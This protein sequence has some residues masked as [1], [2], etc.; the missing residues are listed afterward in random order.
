MPKSRYLAAVLAVCA[1]PALSVFAEE[2]DG[3]R[4][5]PLE[6]ELDSMQHL[7]I[8]TLTGLVEGER[9]ELGRGDCQ[10]I[11]THTDADFE[12]G[13]YTA[14]AGFSESE[15]AAASYTLAP[16]EFP[17]IVDRVEMIF[18][19]VGTTVTT[20][21]KWSVGVW[22]GTPNNGTLVALFSSDGTILPHIV[23]PPGNSGVNVQVEV[24][25]ND[26]E[27]I[28]VTNNGSNTFTV[29]YRI[30]EHHNQTA[31]PCFTAPPQTSNAFPVTDTSGLANSTG[32]WLFGLNCG[33]F[34]CPTNGGWASFATLNSLC[35]PSGDWVI[36]ATYTPTTCVNDIG[37][38][39]FSNGLCF[40]MTQADC[41][42]VDGLFNGSDTLCAD[43]S[44][45]IGACCVPDGSCLDGVFEET[46]EIEL[47]GL[48]LGDETE[49]ANESCPELVEA[50][51]FDAGCVNLTPTNCLNAGG[52]PGGPGTTCAT[53]NCNPTGACCMPDGSCVDAVSPSDCADA[54]GTYQGDD[55]ACASVSCPEPFGACCFDNGFCLDLVEADCIIAGGVWAGPLTDCATDCGDDC[56][57]DVTGDDSIDL[58]D[59]NVVL[60]QFGQTGAD[61]QG[62]AD[63]SGT[64]DL[65]DL[66]LV[67]ASFGQDC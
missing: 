12:G 49:C 63:D 5:V 14:Q 20:T 1:L 16:S 13:A 47:N 15:W 42:S 53:Y 4:P 37:A 57:A 34:G 29:G 59:L 64:V 48:Y 18:A 40:E 58:A 36:R 45:A 61:L 30:D 39:C 60:S 31:N 22:E 6:V 32:N 50:C 44:C 52:T 43:F 33:P 7:R 11:V 21:T 66:N 26:P 56:P 38:C 8:N 51:C 24:D 55:V 67:L 65:G 27:Q 41:D 10:S 35:R 2:P 17:L 9:V 25:P 19:T 28:V 46:C 3:R 23:M 54:G 62:D